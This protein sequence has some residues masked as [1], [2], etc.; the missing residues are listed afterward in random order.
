MKKLFFILTLV[1]TMLFGSLALAD[2]LYID[3]TTWMSYFFH[4]CGS[5]HGHRSIE[6]GSYFGRGTTSCCGSRGS[7]FNGNSNNSKWWDFIECWE[8][9]PNRD[10][11]RLEHIQY[12][13][14]TGARVTRVEPLQN[15]IYD[16][17]YWHEGNT[18]RISFKPGLPVDGIV[19]NNNQIPKVKDGYGYNMYTTIAGGGDLHTS[20]A[21]V[22]NG[23]SQCPGTPYCTPSG[24]HNP[25]NVQI[26]Y[27]LNEGGGIGLIFD[28]KFRVYYTFEPEKPV[29]TPDIYLYEYPNGDKCVNDNVSTQ[30]TIGVRDYSKESNGYIYKATENRKW[31]ISEDR[32]N[33]KVLYYRDL[34]DSDELAFYDTASDGF[35]YWQK[36]SDGEVS[37]DEPVS[38]PL[39]TYQLTPNQQ[40][41][42]RL[43]IDDC[44]PVIAYTS[45]WPIPDPTPT[46]TPDP[47]VYPTVDPTPSGNH[48]TATITIKDNSE[49]VIGKTINC[50]TIVTVEDESTRDGE[51]YNAQNRSWEIK[52][53][54]ADW[55]RLNFDN[56]TCIKEVYSRADKTKKIT[57]DEAKAENSEASNRSN[58][59]HPKFTYLLSIPNVKYEFRLNIR[60]EDYKLYSDEADVSTVN[61]GYIIGHNANAFDILNDNGDY[62]TDKIWEKIENTTVVKLEPSDETKRT[63]SRYTWNYKESEE[64]SYQFL[65]N[66]VSPSYTIEKG[67][68]YYFQLI[69]GGGKEEVHYTGI[70]SSTALSPYVNIN[71]PSAIDLTSVTD[72]V[73]DIPIKI[74]NLEYLISEEGIEFI[75]E[76]TGEVETI[77]FTTVIPENWEIS[78]IGENLDGGDKYILKSDGTSELYTSTSNPTI[79]E[80]PLG[81]S[82]IDFN[83]RTNISSVTTSTSKTLKFTVNAKLN[84]NIGQFIVE[85]SS[86]TILYKSGGTSLSGNYPINIT[87]INNLSPDNE[88]VIEAGNTFTLDLDH[89]YTDNLEL[90]AESNIFSGG[91]KDLTISPAGTVTLAATGNY[92]TGT[93]VNKIHVTAN[94]PDGTHSANQTI[95]IK[96]NWIFDPDPP[97]GGSSGGSGGDTAL[98]LISTR[99]MRWQNYYNQYRAPYNIKE[100][101]LLKPLYRN[102]QTGSYSTISSAASVD[103]SQLKMGYA[104]ELRLELTDLMSNYIK[105]NNGRIEIKVKTKVDGNDV[106][107]KYRNNSG[108]HGIGDYQTIVLSKNTPHKDKFLVK[109]DGNYKNWTFIHY[110][111]STSYIAVGDNS[112]KTVDIYFDSI[113]AYEDN[114]NTKPLFNYID[115]A[116]SKYNWNGHVY[117]YRTDV[118]NLQDLGYN[119][120]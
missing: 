73:I 30:K 15:N 46:P 34:Q 58:L 64:E 47:T 108:E 98:K 32:V 52:I 12:N 10:N 76:E 62:V 63:T 113:I 33:W 50:G 44:A 106:T 26:T 65:S 23:W 43:T 104:V 110:L 5:L 13:I 17:K 71:S 115:L 19:N 81:T 117:T 61:G 91:T 94:H 78:L 8:S 20:A 56:D 4:S 101:V 103:I 18:V 87:V 90:S 2:E 74:H 92:D 112:K 53:G 38:A 7:L 80:H 118:N 95:T 77:E 28:Y 68:T 102:Y 120:N 116:K 89:A 54:D 99:D 29:V 75:D 48:L 11:L 66:D 27:L 37:L 114:T 85:D 119:A 21:P 70:I 16:I 86:E 84:T 93:N 69:T 83:W 35:V 40:T 14:P 51:F 72:E 42:F 41:Y 39:F 82:S 25:K 59:Q 111:P 109:H 79:D 67:K 31:E 96:P 45:Y 6:V 97:G 3:S 1:C 107:M 24:K 22:D 9:Y 36:V 49:D 100:G 55:R 60:D 88:K 57:I 105:N